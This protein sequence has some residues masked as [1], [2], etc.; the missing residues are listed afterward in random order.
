MIMV[1]M[2]MIV[3]VSGCSGCDIGHF[4]WPSINQ[5]VVAG[6][7]AGVA[8]G[9]V[10]GVCAGAVVEVAGTGPAGAGAAAAGSATCGSGLPPFDLTHASHLSI[11]FASTAIAI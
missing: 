9:A 7:A 1:V 5:F 8:P 11:G 6:E 4:L 10:A 3:A 2:R